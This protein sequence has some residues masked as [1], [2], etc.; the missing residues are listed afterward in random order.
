MLGCVRMD[1]VL[2]GESFRTGRMKR[3]RNGLGD[4][5][6]EASACSTALRISFDSCSGLAIHD[7]VSQ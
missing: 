2:H 1:C 3:T 5:V 6:D 4:I 7:P